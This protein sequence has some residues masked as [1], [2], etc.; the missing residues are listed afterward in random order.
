MSG[1]ILD[2]S[3]NGILVNVPGTGDSICPG[4]KVAVTIN[5]MN[6]SGTVRHVSPIAGGFAVGIHLG[7]VEF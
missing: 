4:S 6:G 2:V 5:N 7:S 1:Q 3:A